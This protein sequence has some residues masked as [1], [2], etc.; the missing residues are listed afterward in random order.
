MERIEMA[1]LIKRRKRSKADV[2][3]Q[4]VLKSKRMEKWNVEREKELREKWLV[5]R[6]QACSH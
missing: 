1:K 4:S 3:P 6:E 2:I 5:S